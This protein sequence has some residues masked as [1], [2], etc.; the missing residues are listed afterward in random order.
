MPKTEYMPS[1]KAYREWLEK[2]KGLM[3]KKTALSTYYGSVTSDSASSFFGICAVNGLCSANEDLIETDIVRFFEILDGFLCLDAEEAGISKSAFSSAGSHARALLEYKKSQL[4]K[5]YTANADENSRELAL[6][7]LKEL[8][9]AFGF[10]RKYDA[11]Y[12][13]R[14]TLIGSYILAPIKERVDAVRDF[15]V[16]EVYTPE[17]NFF[18]ISQLIKNAWRTDRTGLISRLKR[19]LLPQIKKIHNERADIDQEPTDI[20]REVLYK[21]AH[22]LWLKLSQEPGFEGSVFDAMLCRMRSFKEARLERVDE[23]EL[24]ALLCELIVSAFANTGKA[25]AQSML[26]YPESRKDRCLIA[27]LIPLLKKIN[28][29]KLKCEVLYNNAYLKRLL[30]IKAIYPSFDG[31]DI[32]VAKNLRYELSL[33]SSGLLSAS[34]IWSDN[35]ELELL[36]LILRVIYSGMLNALELKN[37]DSELFSLTDETRALLGAVIDT[38]TKLKAGHDLKAL[39]IGSFALCYLYAMYIEK[40]H[41]IYAAERLLQL[42][43]K[44]P[45]ELIPTLKD[46]AE[47]TGI[48]LDISRANGGV[49][50]IKAEW[51]NIIAGSYFEKAVGTEKEQAGSLFNRAVI[52]A[53][54]ALEITGGYNN[55]LELDALSLL[56]K[57]EAHLCVMYAQAYENAGLEKYFYSEYARPLLCHLDKIKAIGKEAYNTSLKSAREIFK[58]LEKYASFNDENDSLL[59]SLISSGELHNSLRENKNL[60]AL[61]YLPH[62]IDKSFLLS[63]FY[64]A[65]F[66]SAIASHRGF[67]VSDIELPIMNLLLTMKPV[68]L[69]PN[70]IIDHD[71]LLSLAEHPGYLDLYKRGYINLSFYNSVS[72]REYAAKQLERADFEWSSSLGFLN[73]TDDAG[74]NADIMKARKHVADYLRGKCEL[75]SA[76]FTAINAGTDEYLFVKR[77]KENLRL[78]DENCPAI[79]RTFYYQHNESIGN[80]D[81]L[82]TKWLDNSYN[83]KSD[84]FFVERTIHDIITQSLPDVKEKGYKRTH[85]KV[86]LDRILHGKLD[87]FNMNKLQENAI[88]SLA[89]AEKRKAVLDPMYD[90]LHDCYNYVVG[91]LISADQFR[92]YSSEASVP[93]LDDDYVSLKN[94]RFEARRHDSFVSISE[95]GRTIKFDELNE[96]LAGIRARIDESRTLSELESALNSN[97]ETASRLEYSVDERGV[98]IASTAFEITNGER[99]AI[100]TQKGENKVVRIGF[101]TKEK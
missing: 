31:E 69:S 7:V 57:A 13:L 97:A 4:Y 26:M 29:E 85:Y 40:E 33:D 3:N 64:V 32:L 47:C 94:R 14:D 27:F 72:V 98:Q 37:Y 90:A 96:Y 30:E 39:L 45:Q 89:D 5:Q 24:Y 43:L 70:Q 71:I 75:E 11:Y 81:L 19:V 17:N 100:D 22:S 91:S 1:H 68:I 74:L 15:T 53:K 50:L 67:G 35:S 28:R 8:T 10:G 36:E 65:D 59:S 66:D 73:C 6:T 101:E 16:C 56:V 25:F 79:S 18:L 62:G 58:G 63:S 51:Q 21:L 86:K 48:S 60:S 88:L 80:S 38:K 61:I 44:S 46:F 9:S 20:L 49:H 52:C 2:E 78:I 23:K 99:L 42:Y 54:D 77:Y 12:K 95:T 84:G 93:M 34:E 92:N 55:T 83:R 82:L 41:S 87:G 76:Y